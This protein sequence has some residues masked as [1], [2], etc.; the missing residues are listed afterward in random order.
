MDSRPVRVLLVSTHPV[1]YGV[2]LYRRYAVH[3]A[4]NVTIAYCSLHGAERGFDPEFGIDLQWD[5]P[6]L[7]GYTWVHLPNRSP[8]PSLDRFFGLLNPGIW[9]LIREGRYEIVVCYGYHAASFWIAGAAAKISGAALVLSTDAHT[10]AP[11]DGEAWKGPLKRAVL[12]RLFAAADAVFA[13]SSRTV[14]Y[15]EGLGVRSDRIFL[16]PYTV[17]NGSFL[18]SAAAAD[19][20]AVRARWALPQEARVALFVGKLVPWKRPMDLVDA[21]AQVDGLYVI[22]AG[23]GPMRDSVEAR[24]NELGVLARMRFLGFV[25]RRALPEVYAAS[26]WLVLPSQ[27]EGFGLVINE[28][29]ACGRPAIVSDACGAVGDLVLDG[30]TGFVIPVGDTALL[31]RRLQTLTN[32]SNL[33]RIMGARARRRIADWGPEANVQAFVA[34]CITLAGES[35]SRGRAD[36]KVV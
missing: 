9:R 12:P 14:G 32:D 6:L 28:A 15:L 8:H 25:N 22:W 23:A 21:A 31:T 16:T 35:R 26:D 29:F 30:E 34:A 4:L 19:I 13:P 11:R 36:L 3:P 2:P 33:L 10:A 7:D 27:Y 5:I 20:A 1:Q 24:A 18:E 17:D